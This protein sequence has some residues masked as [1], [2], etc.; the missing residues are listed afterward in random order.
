MA[1]VTPGD[2]PEA[3]LRAALG[4]TFTRLTEMMQ[5]MKARQEKTDL[6][7]KELLEKAISP[8]K[9]KGPGPNGEEDI[10]MSKSFTDL[11]KNHGKVEGFENWRFTMS[12]F[13]SKDEVYVEL[14]RWVEKE[15][16]E[17]EIMNV[18][19]Y[20]REHNIDLKWYNSQ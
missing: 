5:E 15:G 18:R 6:Q 12:Q 11:P 14:L 3:D 19:E 17:M 4:N 9:R 7:M 8:V 20:E 13:L 10:T 1:G 16:I 2:G